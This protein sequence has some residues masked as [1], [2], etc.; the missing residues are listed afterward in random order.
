MAVTTTVPRRRTALVAALAAVTLVCVTLGTVLLV[1]AHSLSDDPATANRALLD[2]TTTG[3]AVGQVSTALNQMLSYDYR[4]PEV[5]QAAARRWLV[6]DAPA[7]Y[8][9]LFRQLQ[10]LAPNQKLTLVARVTSAGVVELHGRTAR[11]LVF[12]DQQSTRATDG[13]SS[14]SA[15]QVQITAVHRAAGWRISELKPL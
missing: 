6:G 12:L 15:A 3:E 11:L 7:Q 8:T 10:Q 9:L 2:R 1:R 5:A 13:Q 4:K 14:V